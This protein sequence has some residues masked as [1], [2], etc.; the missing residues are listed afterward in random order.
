M[1][2]TDRGLTCPSCGRPPIDPVSTDAVAYTCSQCLV[3]GRVSPGNPTA[4]ASQGVDSGSP[5]R[6]P[7]ELLTGTGLP[8]GQ[9][10]AGSESGKLLAV[11]AHRLRAAALERRRSPLRSRFG[12]FRDR[13]PEYRERE[14][15]RKRGAAE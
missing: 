10:N 14:Q 8:D 5:I 7:S 12:R 2:G 3:F 11:A 9:R 15:R 1:T 6:T 4:G 13:H